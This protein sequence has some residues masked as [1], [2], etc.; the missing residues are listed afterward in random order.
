MK[1][2]Q[3]RLGHADPR[4]TLVVYAQVTSEGDR[5]AADKV[6]ARFLERGTLARQCAMD[7]PLLSPM[8]TAPWGPTSRCAMDAPWSCA[9][10]RASG[11]FIHLTREDSGFWSGRRDS[12]PR[13]Q[14]PERCALTKLRHFPPGRAT[15][16]APC[17]RI[18]ECSPARCSRVCCVFAGVRGCLRDD[19]RDAPPVH[20][21]Y[22]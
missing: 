6:A 1:A 2:A 16:V 22:A 17:P 9:L 5:A 19:L 20:L 18:T 7:A 11:G 21:D 13:P 8:G 15:I 3:A 12:N 4:M 14:R 10:A